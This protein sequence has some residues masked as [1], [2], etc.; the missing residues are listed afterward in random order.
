MMAITP[1]S[2]AEMK[3]ES[4]ELLEELEDGE[5]TLDMEDVTLFKRRLRK[6]E[7]HPVPPFTRPMRAELAERVRATHRSVRGPVEVPGWEALV[8]ENARQG[9]PPRVLVRRLVDELESAWWSGKS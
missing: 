6:L 5:A 8:R 9:G 1:P 4:T 2:L 3:K 7:P